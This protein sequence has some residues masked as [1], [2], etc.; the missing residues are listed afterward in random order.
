MDV[1]Q[2]AVNEQI[3]RLT[4]RG[5]GE[6]DSPHTH[7][8]IQQCHLIYHQTTEGH[9]MIF[10][11][12]MKMLLLARH[13]WGCLCYCDYDKLILCFFLKKSVLVDSEK[14]RDITA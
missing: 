5:T 9:R 11:L 3:I 4:K 14:V 13:K 7:R 10:K 6:Q 12:L 8:N 2:S 1:F